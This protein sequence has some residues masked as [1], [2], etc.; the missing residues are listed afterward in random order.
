MP[1]A[2]KSYFAFPRPVLFHALNVALNARELTFRKRKL[3]FIQEMISITL[4]LVR[5][6]GPL[7]ANLLGLN[8][9]LNLLKRLNGLKMLIGNVIFEAKC[10]GHGQKSTFL[11]YK[12]RFKLI[13]Q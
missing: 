12:K 4:V 10:F 13:C 1:V 6:L 11:K 5:K 9:G 8:V 3:A 7:H 2:P